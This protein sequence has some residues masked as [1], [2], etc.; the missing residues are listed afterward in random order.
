VGRSERTLL[1]KEEEM[2]TN[3]SIFGW[4]YPPGCSGPPEPGPPLEPIVCAL[5]ETPL[6]YKLDDDVY[7]VKPCK[8]CT[9][10]REEV[11][12]NEERNERET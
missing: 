8:K 12:L 4:S 5:C 2:T 10:L 9:V 1:R 7:Y 6:D 11:E 3:K